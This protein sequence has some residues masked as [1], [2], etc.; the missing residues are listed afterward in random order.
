L[1]NGTVPKPGYKVKP[2]DEIRASI[3]APVTP[4]LQ[5]EPI[6][7]D[8]LYEDSDLVVI[9]KPKNIVV[10]PSPGHKSGTL[11][12]ALLAHCDNLSGVGGI[13]RPGIVHRLDKD[14]S[15]VLVVAKNDDAHW[16]LAD[17]LRKHTMKRRYVALVRGDIANERGIID[18]P[19]GRH[20]VDRKKMA[21]VAR[22]M[23][24]DAVTRFEVLERFGTYT[25]IRLTL[26]TG[27]THQ[28]RV[29]MYYI[30][31]PVAGDPKYGNAQSDNELG[32][33]S[34]ALHA[35]TLGFRHPG[36]GEYL[37]FSSPLP[38]DFEKALAILRNRKNKS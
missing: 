7:L 34:Q 37:E 5:P 6:P 18:A 2:G 15:G 30:G 36:T 4:E 3:P 22:R 20:P 23:G 35:E 32:L 27:R 38:E 12:N 14:T 1:I 8:I 9:N 28:I 10:H 11:V 24:K 26:R 33:E 29:H 31:H 13:R 19:I 21:V 16:G 17:Q 25:F